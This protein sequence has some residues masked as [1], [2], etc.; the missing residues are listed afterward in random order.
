M[1]PGLIVKARNQLVQVGACGNAVD[2]HDLDHAPVLLTVE[3][4]AEFQFLHFQ[5]FSQQLLCLNGV[6]EH[7]VMIDVVDLK[8]GKMGKGIPSSLSQLVACLHLQ[9]ALGCRLNCTEVN[10]STDKAPT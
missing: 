2:G 8:A 1:F 6:A 3:N 5:R 9:E 10:I 7:V 4:A